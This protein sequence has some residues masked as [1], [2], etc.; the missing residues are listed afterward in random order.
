MKKT[1]LTLFLLMVM[2]PAFPE[3]VNVH[4]ARQV[5]QTFLNS[6][7]GNAQE[8]HLINFAE[9]TSFSNF[10]VFGNEHCFVII[11]ADDCVHP[12]LGYSTEG[13]FSTDALPEN[14]YFWLKTYSETITAISENKI[15]ATSEILSEWDNLLNGKG[16]GSKSGNSVKPLIRTKWNQGAPYN[17][18]CPADNAGPNG[19]SSAGCVAIAMAQIMKYWEHPVKGEGQHSYTPKTHPEFGEQFAN[20]GE[21]VY[22]WNS[23][24][25]INN[26]TQEYKEAVATLVYHC[27]VAVDMDYSSDTTGSSGASSDC[28]VKALQNHFRYDHC[29]ELKMKDSY[30][31]GKK[32]INMLKKELDEQRPVFYVGTDTAYSG[33]AFVCDGYDE[34]EY[35]HF[36]WGWPFFSDGYYIID[37]LNPYANGHNYHFNNDV[38]AIVGCKPVVSI[39]P[40]MDVVASA[41]KRDVTIDWDIVNDAVSYKLYRD[42]ELVS[43]TLT[44]NSYFDNNV[45]YG[46]HRYYVKS[47]GADG[48]TSLKSNT[49]VVEILYQ[50]PWL[51][52]A[53]A[54]DNDV[55]LSWTLNGLKDAIL[56]YGFGEAA[57]T[58][59]YPY[60]AQKYPKSVLCDYA[61]MAINKVSVCFS[62][63]GLYELYLCSGTTLFQSGITTYYAPYSGWQEIMLDNPVDLDYS[64]DLWV[65][66]HSKDGAG[67][68]SY[69][70]YDA[71]DA[72]D[73]AYYS[74]HMSSFYTLD[75]SY[76]W[77]I[78]THLTDG[79]HSYN[80]YRDGEVVVSNYYYNTYND[81]NLPDGNYVYYI[82]SNYSGGE[83]LPSN[84][85]IVTIGDPQMFALFVDGKLVIPHDNREAIFQVIDMKGS[86]IKSDT[87][88]GQYKENLNLKPGV[89]V[90]RLIKNKT[91]KTQKIVIN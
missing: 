47:V 39:L 75:G 5:A 61:G 71:S 49:V 16:L 2:L 28:V 30:F 50:G 20:F 3:H 74:V 77:L 35:F 21:T 52:N 62:Q 88:K 59:N 80:I 31:S 6:K 57:G 65:V 67:A 37:D 70:E 42:D 32:W 33:H 41:E 11:A 78:K 29:M 83:S 79:V 24:S 81:I 25:P 46:E 64:Q 85:R 1:F 89:Y 58:F 34:D 13:G 82:T 15:E 19:H 26:T 56:Q 22:D 44:S 27:G 91:I 72:S 43:D 76:S 23:M 7:I 60:Y 48:T 87:F 38:G 84:R 14:I 68:V 51:D 54:N 45:I 69:C 17:D 90:L 73:A 53:Y 40:P 86:I 10:Y 55:R 63:P 9:K 36:N 66:L 18:F 8:I 4:T 12:V